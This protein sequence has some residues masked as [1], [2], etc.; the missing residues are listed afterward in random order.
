MDERYD[1]GRG[2]YHIAVCLLTQEELIERF[3]PTSPEKRRFQKLPH[4]V[5]VI[6]E[7]AI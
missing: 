1:A 3:N 6:D 4:I 2:G 5:I 7:L